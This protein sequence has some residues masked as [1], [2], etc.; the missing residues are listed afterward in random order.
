MVITSPEVTLEAN[1]RTIDVRHAKQLRSAGVSRL[2]IGVQSIIDADLRV[3]GRSHNAQDAI[4]CVIEMSSIFDN[5]SIDMIYNRPNQKLGDWI[6]ELNTAL[7]LPIKHISL[8]ELIIEKGTKIEEMIA[9]GVLSMPSSDTA[10][11]D[12]TAIIAESHGFKRYEVSNFAM[13][14]YEGRH[15]LGYWRYEDYYGVGPSSHSRLSKEVPQGTSWVMQR[16]PGPQKDT[17]QKDDQRGK[18]RKLAIEQISQIS[19]WM[20]WAENPVFVVEHLSD[21]EIFKERLIVGL[22]S[23][24]GLDLQTV[25]DELKQRYG[26]DHKMRA[27]LQNSCIMVDDGVMT[28][29]RKGVAKLNMI[30]DYISREWT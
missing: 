13:E 12:E 6:E 8:Y 4:S 18:S 20:R 24:I 19:E 29:T 9:S 11:F 27:L 30:V 23:R 17:T 5:I 3:L 28:L 15:N 26:L 25:P 22:R 1:P 2:S 16:T 14:G 7:S 10:F 21:D